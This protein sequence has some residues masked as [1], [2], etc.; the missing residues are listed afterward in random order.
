[1]KGKLENKDHLP[2]FY[3][4]S[5]GKHWSF[6]NSQKGQFLK[7]YAHTKSLNRNVQS[8]R[9]TIT[10]LLLKWQEITIGAHTVQEL[11]F[12]TILIKFPF[13][14]ACFEWL[15]FKVIPTADNINFSKSS[16]QD[17]WRRNIFFFDQNF[18]IKYIFP[19]AIFKSA[20]FYTLKSTIL[21]FVSCK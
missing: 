9:K 10:W 5:T 19:S 15:Q 16:E 4:F 11:F 17:T 14:V 18:W 1:M 7:I 13:E 8:S 21:K 3:C 20:I 12:F 6:P 2:Y